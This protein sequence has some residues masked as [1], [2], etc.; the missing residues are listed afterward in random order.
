M[1]QRPSATEDF[2]RSADAMPKRTMWFSK[3]LPTKLAHNSSFVCLSGES[4]YLRPV[5]YFGGGNYGSFHDIAVFPRYVAERDPCRFLH[6][7]LT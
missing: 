7:R 1:E 2:T 4:D 6:P 5:S 3:M